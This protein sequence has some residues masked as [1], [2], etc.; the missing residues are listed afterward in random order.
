MK[1][2]NFRKGDEIRLGIKTDKGII[3]VTEAT[4]TA[5]AE[6][7]AISV[8]APEAIERRM[9]LPSTMEQVIAGG[10]QAL[11]QLNELIGKNPKTIPEESI[12]YAPC[13]M[14]PEKILCVGLNY[15]SHAEECGL[16]IPKFPVLFSKFNNALAAHKQMIKL[17]AKAEKFDYEAE[18]VIVIGREAVN[19]SK[20]E[21][22]SFVFGYTIG[23]DL[24]ARDLQL[25]TG[26]WLLGKTCD[27]FAPIGPYIVTADEVDP[28]NMDI[29]C[30]VN[31]KVRQAANTR[32]M[33]FDCAS[34]VSYISQ[35]MT[36]KPGD[37]IFTGTPSGVVLG[38]IEAQQQWLVAGDKIRVSI[39]KLGT[40][41]NQLCD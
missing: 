40:L 13:V 17:P 27:G 19:V 38:K 31:G 36:L 14:K 15:Y 24:S 23:N 32:E 25:R 4:K 2:L 22:L 26:Q 41:E 28:D 3:D 35:Y 37:I 34:I 1:L 8:I 5:T 7:A 16:S 33:I 30:E 9:I 20:E 29:G 10:E 39:E 6:T 18:L 11:A 12:I 21:A